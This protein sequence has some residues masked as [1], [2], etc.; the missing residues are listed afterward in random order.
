LEEKL[1]QE[2]KEQYKYRKREQ[3]IDQ[4]DRQKE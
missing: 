1:N 2:G 4:R 3:G